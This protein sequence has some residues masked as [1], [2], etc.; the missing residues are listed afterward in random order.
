MKK[1]IL[2]LLLLVVMLVTALPLSVLPSLASTEEEKTFEEADYNALYVQDGLTVALDYFT[3]NTYWGKP[4][5]AT[6][7]EAYLWQWNCFTADGAR[8][9]L[10]LKADAGVVANGYMRLTANTQLG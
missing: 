8:D 1:R 6:N 9:R 4:A 5:L 2:S 7:A 10:L 3:T